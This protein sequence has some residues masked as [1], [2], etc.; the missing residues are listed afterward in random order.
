MRPIHLDDDAQTRGRRTLV[1]ALQGCDVVVAAT[2]ADDDVALRL[3]NC[4]RRVHAG[5]GAREVLDPRVT[6]FN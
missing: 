4:V 3:G 6:Q 2:V 5:P 1:H